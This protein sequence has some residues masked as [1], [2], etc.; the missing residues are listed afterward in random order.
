LADASFPG[1]PHSQGMTRTVAPGRTLPAPG[2]RPRS[3]APIEPVAI[4]GWVL[5]L[6]SGEYARCLPPADIA[7]WP[8][9]P[10]RLIVVSTAPS[11][12]ISTIVTA[13]DVADRN[14]QVATRES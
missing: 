7:L 1:K 6:S 11:P 10:G 4:A 12:L 8:L 9:R 13:S 3:N 5:R 2:P 14:A